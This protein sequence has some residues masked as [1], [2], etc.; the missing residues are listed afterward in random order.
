M[1]LS[2]VCG[3][4]IANSQSLFRLRAL[5]GF[6]SVAAVLAAL[7]A[8]GPTTA[9]AQTTT[10]I[11]LGNATAVDV[12]N[13]IHAAR[14][15]DGTTGTDDAAAW[16]NP[17]PW[18]A[19]NY[20]MIAEIDLGATY[21]LDSLRYFVGNL[22]QGQDDIY[23]EV[24]SEATGENFDWLGRQNH[25]HT[26]NEWTTVSLNQPWARRVRVIFNEQNDR[27]N[28]GELELFGTRVGGPT[29]P[30][31]TPPTPT[32]TSA[33][34]TLPSTTTTAPPLPPTTSAP[35]VNPTVPT[36][37]ESMPRDAQPGPDIVRSHGFGNWP[38]D[39]L[40]AGCIDL[41][42]RYWIQ[43]Q[44]VGI[45]N[46]PNHP[47]NIAYPT[48]HPAVETH[49]DTGE[50]CDYGHEHGTSPLLAP[51]EV[52][53]LSGG[54]PAFGYAAT[55]AGP[56]R[57]EDHVGHKVTVAK[58]RAAIGNGAGSETLY[59]A[60]FD[61]D[62]LS[63]IHQGS[64]SMDAFSNHLH[65]YFLTVRCFD[66]E[67]AAGVQDGQT[68][69]TAFS[70]KVMFTYG[71]PNR[72]VEE[73]CA[74][75]GDFDVS[76]LSSPGG[77]HI[78]RAQ[79]EDPVGNNSSNDR[80]F[81]CSD[82][83][84]W[85]TLD[86]DAPGPVAPVS[87]MDIWN[88]LIKIESPDGSDAMTIQPYYMV[89]NSSR[90]IEGFA[91]GDGPSQVVRTIDLCYDDDGNKLGFFL[92]EDAPETNP[93]WMSSDSPFNGAL[94]SVHFKAI[95]LQNSGGPSV[96]CTNPFGRRVNDPLPCEPGN[97][98]QRAASYDNDFNNGQYSYNGRQ[99]NVA[100][101][102]WAEVVGGHRTTTQPLGGGAYEPNGIGFE[103]VIDNR[104][105]DDNNDGIP[106]GANL[107]GAN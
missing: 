81:V 72:F 45:S 101:S 98:E 91:P 77:E 12:S 104:D 52:F 20:P 83:L 73:N 43:G 87:Y 54:W 53:E 48:W 25:G 79:R 38:N 105:P 3:M 14:L 47:D 26:W 62:W 28:I 29:P 102:I 78:H 61:C 33:A 94:R 35:T 59:D 30:T 2:G 76:V 96:F 71:R 51:A 42:D 58:F 69:G 24:S 65:E 107:R 1:C 92:C 32:T 6:V 21:Q 89:K 39:H 63:K 8:V 4:N 44:N 75:G 64:H 84:V 86:Q 68:V 16:L 41:H 19:S 82:A 67:N 55:K 88:E 49:P 34:P 15:I 37:V 9:G 5:F 27:F 95:S 100:G 74:A 56:P 57:H 60:G 17:S 40:S 11:P 46:D 7:L 70:I 36:G 10:A 31:T 99:G 97:I 106:D 18:Q 22:T 90:V 103:F 66:G 93:G 50:V 85:N 13:S 23:F 80:A